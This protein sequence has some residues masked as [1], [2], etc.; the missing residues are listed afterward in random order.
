MRVRGGRTIQ[1]LGRRRM[2][3]GNAEPVRRARTIQYSTTTTTANNSE[4]SP[5][6]SA[7]GLYPE[8]ILL[9][10]PLQDL[11]F[12]YLKYLACLHRLARDLAPPLAHPSLSTHRIWSTHFNTLALQEEGIDIRTRLHWTRIALFF[13][14][15]HFVHLLAGHAKATARTRLHKTRHT[16]WRTI[17]RQTCFWRMRLNMKRRTR[18]RRTS[19]GG[20]SIECGSGGTT[21]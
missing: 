19:S 6:N 18:R 4:Q 16:L 2:F 7:L 15:L 3:S 9:W 14:F 1:R 17:A 20:W 8:T 10:R 21:R 5:T 12:K 11:C 13:P